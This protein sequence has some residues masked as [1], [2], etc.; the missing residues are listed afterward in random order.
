MHA[1]GHALLSAKGHT[2]RAQ[3]Q[4]AAQAGGCTV[5]ELVRAGLRRRTS[6]AAARAVQAL[7]AGLFAGLEAWPVVCSCR[8]VIASAAAVV[9]CPLCRVEEG[10]A[11]CVT[12]HGCPACR[13]AQAKAIEAAR[14]ARGGD[15]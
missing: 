2:V 14:A 8:A 12:G 5:D 15:K 9:V 13:A 6:I 11:V 4:A 1:E 7:P 3:L 10:C